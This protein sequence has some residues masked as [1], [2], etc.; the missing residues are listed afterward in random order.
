LSTGGLQE[1][2]K[3]LLEHIK[4]LNDEIKMISAT[5]NNNNNNNDQSHRNENHE[6]CPS[7]G[8]ASNVVVMIECQS[9]EDATF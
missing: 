6:C 9:A 1:Q 2:Q 4:D 3:T 5:L 8:L 7:G